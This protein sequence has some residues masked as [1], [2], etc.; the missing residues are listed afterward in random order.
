MSAPDHAMRRKADGSLRRLIR[1]A[2]Q[3]TATATLLICALLALFG[4]L[5]RFS[6][7]FDTAN[8]FAPLWAGL[9]GACAVVAMLLGRGRAR[10][11]ALIAG[12]IVVGAGADRI[13]PELLAHDTALQSAAAGGPRL[14]VLSFNVWKFDQDPA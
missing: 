8:Q 4:L 9:G 14:K 5:G 13:A 3:R 2:A 1:S 10:L 11:V 7:K 6:E 12:S